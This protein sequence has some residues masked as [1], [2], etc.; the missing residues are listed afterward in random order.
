MT[1]PDPADAAPEGAETPTIQQLRLA[2]THGNQVL[3]PLLQRYGCRIRQWIRTAGVRTE[4]DIDDLEADVMVKLLRQLPGTEFDAVG[5][6][7]K[8]VRK[9]ATHCA[10]DH[11]RRHQRNPVRQHLI[12]EDGSAIDPVAQQAGPA[13]EIALEQRVRRRQ[14]L[15]AARSRPEQDLIAMRENQEMSFAAIAEVQNATARQLGILKT[16]TADSVRMAYHR[17]LKIVG[18][19]VDG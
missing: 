19:P 13:T 16:K 2:H 15:I 17:L 3:G 7:R 14:A 18:P 1:E 11:L 8:W 4:P 5:K 6:F 10:I 9:I 12:K